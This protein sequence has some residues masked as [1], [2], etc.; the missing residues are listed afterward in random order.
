MK[1]I[2]NNPH[3]RPKGVPNKFTLEI[4]ER[5]KNLLDEYFDSKEFDNDLQKLD[6]KDRVAF[7]IKLLEYTVPKL[8]FTNLTTEFDRLS[9]EDLNR[10]VQELIVSSNE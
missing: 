6:A 10:I 4:R 9:D 3:G 7:M 2:T 1:G 8:R 5:I